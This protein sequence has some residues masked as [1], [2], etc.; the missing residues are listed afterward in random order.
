MA[1]SAIVASVAVSAVGVAASVSAS[2]KAASASKDIASAQNDANQ[3]SLQAMQTD[4]RR[5][6]L[7]TIRQA[8]IARST[9]TATAVSQNAQLGSGLQGGYAQISGESNWNVLGVNQN[10]D[11]GKE[12]ASI[13]NRI[14]SDRIDM[15]SAQSMAG[16]GQGLQGFGNLMGN[17]IGPL[18]RLT[19][20]F[21]QFPSSNAWYNGR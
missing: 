9:S 18:G 20:N 1:I 2:S 11:F 4:A 7:E 13:N 17:S 8:Q 21:S 12:M 15:A 14:T 5:R 6:Q 19:N 10:V 3:L 16:W